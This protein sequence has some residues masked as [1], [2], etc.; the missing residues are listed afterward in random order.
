MLTPIAPPLDVDL[1]TIDTSLPLI[2]SGEIV[3]FQLFKIELKE[4]NKK[5]G[6]ML[7]IQH[8][9]VSPTKSVKGE[10]LNPGVF[11]FNNIMLN[12]IG[13]STW[14]MVQRSIAELTQAAGLSTTLN[15]FINSGWKQLQGMNVKAKVSYIPEGPDKGGVIRKAK[16]EIAIYLKQ[17]Q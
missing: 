13:K 4:T 2:A 8:K 6:L 17:G 5:D 3:D 7:N 14:E 16:N 15:D 1:N 12:P 11:V 9:S 10:T